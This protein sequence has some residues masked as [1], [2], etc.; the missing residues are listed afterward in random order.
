[1]SIHVYWVGMMRTK[2]KLPFFQ[3][4]TG[5]LKLYS[6]TLGNKASMQHVFSSRPCEYTNKVKHIYVY[7]ACH[8]TTDRLDTS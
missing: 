4:M 1:M 3:N 7:Q 5:M 6:A 2:L 8:D